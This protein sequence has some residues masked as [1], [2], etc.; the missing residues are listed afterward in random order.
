MKGLIT[1]RDLGAPAWIHTRRAVNEVA[2][3]W[4]AGAPVTSWLA[5][6]RP[7]RGAGHRSR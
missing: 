7:D 3:A 1:L 2:K 6:R 5:Q 4:R